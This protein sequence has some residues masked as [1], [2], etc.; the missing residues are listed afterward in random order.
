M[1]EEPRRPLFRPRGVTL[2]PVYKG[3]RGGVDGTCGKLFPCCGA[4]WMPAPPL[5]SRP[6]MAASA[7]GGTFPPL[8]T[9]L[10]LRASGP[11]N[12]CCGCGAAVLPWGPDQYTS[13]VC[14]RCD[15]GESS[16]HMPKRERRAR[17]RG[18]RQSIDNGEFNRAINDV[19]AADVDV[20]AIRALHWPPL[21]A[22]NGWLATVVALHGRPRQKAS[23]CMTLKCE[24]GVSRMQP[25]R[26]NAG[27][28]CTHA[29][30]ARCALAAAH[31]AAWC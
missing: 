21:T 9:R 2:M 27:S 18:V 13:V 14:T 19:T 30:T 29:G 22:A 3:A 1:P 4:L 23:Y 25:L 10:E 28:Q 24:R 12:G 5:I 17:Q 26:V 15:N 16:S 11:S 20:E 6:L 31:R 7:T 8:T